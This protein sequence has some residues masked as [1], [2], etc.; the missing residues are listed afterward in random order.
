MYNNIIIVFSLITLF[1]GARKV[2]WSALHEAV[3]SLIPDTPLL[4]PESTRIDPWVQSQV[5]SLSTNSDSK[6]TN[7]QIEQLAKE[8][9]NIEM[10]TNDSLGLF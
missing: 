3:L 2:V 8:S 7:K 6:Q 5:W 4:S 10:I 1:W 9:I